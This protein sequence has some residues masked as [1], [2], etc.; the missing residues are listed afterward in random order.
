MVRVNTSVATKQGIQNATYTY[1]PDAQV[2]DSYAI[3]LDPAPSAYATGQSFM[4]K[5]NTANTGASS[6]NVNGLG[7]KTLK[8]QHDQDTAT[9]DIEAGSIVEVVYDGTNFQIISI[10][11]SGATDA[12]AI[13]TDGSG[14][15]AG[16][17]DKAT[18]VD[19]DVTVIEDS[20]STNAK[21]KLTWANIKATLKAYFDT[22]Y[23]PLAT[24]LTNT[25]ASFTT[26][27]ETKLNNIEALADVTDA[28]NVGSVNASATSKTPP[29]DADSFPIVDSENANVI[30]R[31]T[32]T[33]LKSFLKTYFDTLYLALSGG[34]LTGDLT[35][36]EN[37]S[38]ALD[39]AGSADGKYTGITV[40]GTSG[41]AQAF[42]DLVYLDPTDSRW[43]A[44]DAN[45]ASGA[46]GDARG[47]LGMVVSAGTDGNACKIL[48]NGIIRADAKF[49]TFTINNPIYASETAGAVTQTQPT[50][51]DVVI[52]IVGSALTA[53]EMYF[54]PDWTYT[55]HT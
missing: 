47:M 27:L 17:T 24:V 22:L 39:P 9:G 14:E 30:K 28:G 1:A 21:K 45:S 44:V 26:A 55:T 48:L 6:L 15:I 5:A 32:F 40:T 8:K 52:R 43:E 25:T 36:G 33:N 13:H 18:P 19:A 35:L 37:A 7:A 41:Y 50:T 34:T 31:L 29:V 42:G 51:T 38:I 49:P 16:L 54:N 11:A 12:T 2:S 10:L 20:A 23:Q 53:D 46:D 3:T 4:F